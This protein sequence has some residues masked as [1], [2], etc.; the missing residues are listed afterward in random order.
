M[1]DAPFSDPALIPIALVYAFLT[2]LAFWLKQKNAVILL[3]L[4]FSVYLLIS[5]FREPAPIQEE[6]LRIPP[7]LPVLQDTLPPEDTVASGPIIDSTVTDSIPETAGLPT[8]PSPPPVAEEDQTLKV[9]TLVMSES[10]DEQLRK[11]IN[12]GRVF[13]V[14]LERIYCFTGIQN[15]GARQPISHVWSHED[16]F[17]SKITMTIGRSNH[18]RAWSFITLREGS[19]G[20]WVVS[21]VDSNNTVLDTIHFTVVAPVLE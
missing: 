12:R 8:Q 14:T 18:W 9:R 4:V 5:I 19:V 10:V 6:P 3:S 20:N 16:Q 17:M 2:V 1:F 7:T 15:L 21:I 11:P 13:P